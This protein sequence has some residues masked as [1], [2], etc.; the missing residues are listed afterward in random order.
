[1]NN[2]KLKR[3]FKKILFFLIVTI[4]LWFIKLSMV[5][6]VS[7]KPYDFV[8]F[9]VQ[10][11][12]TQ[13]W[14][15]TNGSQRVNQTIFTLNT[16][17]ITTSLPADV[18]LFAEVYACVTNDGV[19]DLPNVSYITNSSQ[20]GG[21]RNGN[22]NS[23]NLNIYC[24]VPDGYDGE[25]YKFYFQIYS[26]EIPA[27]GADYF[28]VSSY[29]NFDRFTMKT[30]NITITDMYIT[31]TD[32][33]TNDKILA[34]QG[35]GQQVIINQNGQII[36]NTNS[37]N[38]KLDDLNKN[39]TDETSPNLNG[40]QNSAGWLKPG[41]VDSIVNLPL[42]LLNNLQ[43]NL[44]NTCNPVTVNLPYVNK[45]INLPCISAIYKQI[46]GLDAWFQGIGVIAAAFILYRY[47]M[48]LYNRIDDTL[49]FRENNMQGY[50]DES[51]WGG[52]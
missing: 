34:S 9:G 24:K 21:F 8:I 28:R 19:G 30:L 31:D 51:I 12:P 26:W 17:N 23:V 7:I 18:Q 42:T 32:N 13:N 14:I 10:S 40:L 1:M 35:K 33:Y 47:F 49:S 39:I 11:L 48:Y 15:R 2:F 50:F 25:V 5:H 20:E 52:M 6:A 27:G 16:T 43:T 41:P 45:D 37:T 44:G 38:Q 22:V 29:W 36:D 4:V 3:L 46:N